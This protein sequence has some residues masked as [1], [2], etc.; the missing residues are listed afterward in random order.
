M[1]TKR[2]WKPYAVIIAVL[3]VL[4]LLIG[5][6]IQRTNERNDARSKLKESQQLVTS[7]Q[8]QLAHLEST[9]LPAVNKAV[10]AL[11]AF[12]LH[13]ETTTR[14]LAAV[15]AEDT[16]AM[17]T[18]TAALEPQKLDAQAKVDAF[19]ALAKQCNTR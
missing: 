12:R 2:N 3:A 16:A 13:S 17:N 5:S 1:D 6:G 15:V 18:E 11:D 14:F 19:T 8:K 4:L 9:C 10:E 7:V